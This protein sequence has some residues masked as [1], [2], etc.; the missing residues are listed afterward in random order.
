MEGE[1][2]VWRE[3]LVGEGSNE[4]NK[5]RVERNNRRRREMEGG[6]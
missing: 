1:K 2:Y 3:R 5:E 6:K 4:E